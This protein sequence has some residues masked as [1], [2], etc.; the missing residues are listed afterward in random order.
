MSMEDE[1][2]KEL[3]TLKN[4]PASKLSL[5]NY[6]VKDQLKAFL[7]RGHTTNIATFRLEPK[8]ELFRPAVRAETL[9]FHQSL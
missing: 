6:V 2:K 1:K 5:L 8:R 7:G 9:H 4:I 3:P